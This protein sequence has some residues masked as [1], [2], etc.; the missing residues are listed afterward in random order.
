MGS[1]PI[2]HFK[3]REF[4][5]NSAGNW[6]NMGHLKAKRRFTEIKLTNELGEAMVLNVIANNP[7][8]SSREIS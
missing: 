1:Y 2:T 8:A 5:T 3:I 6:K 7:H 4:S